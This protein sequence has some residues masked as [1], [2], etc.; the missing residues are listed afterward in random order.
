MGEKGN[1]AETVG[2]GTDYVSVAVTATQAAGS[3]LGKEVL[4]KAAEITADHAVGEVR[5]RIKKGKAAEA[6]PDEPTQL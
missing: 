5:E 4:T 3:H 1:V 2:A 6:G